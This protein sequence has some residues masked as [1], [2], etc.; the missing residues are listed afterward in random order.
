VGE[1]VEEGGGGGGGGGGGTPRKFGEG[2]SARF[3]KPLFYL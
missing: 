1:G 2:C 3:P